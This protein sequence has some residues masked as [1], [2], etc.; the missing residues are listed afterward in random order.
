MSNQVAILGGG[1]GGL[2]A[3]HELIARG[4]SVTVYERESTFG[5]KCKSQS[6][7][8]TA[9]GGR[10]DLPTE[11]GFR[12][13]PG[14]YRHLPDVMSQIPIHGGRTCADLL[15]PTTSVLL[16]MFDKPGLELPTVFP[17]S[18][19]QMFKAAVEVFKSHLGL[20]HGEAVFFLE[21][22]WR[23]MSSCEERRLDELES[24]SWWD[25]IEADSH[26]EAYQHVLG[27]GLS[28]SL[29]A[30]RAKEASARTVGQVQVHLLSHILLGGEAT[31]RLLV[32]PTS[33]VF[34]NPW[35][36]YLSRKG[37]KFVNDAQVESLQLQ[38]NRIGGAQVRN[39]R[40]GTVQSVEADWFVAALPIE[41]FVP[42]ITP[43]LE[44]IDRQFTNLKALVGDIRWMSG[45]QFYLSDVVN[46]NHGHTLHVDT[47][48]A[49]TSISQFQFWD[50]P[51]NIWGDGQVRTLLSVVISDWGTPGLNGKTALE[52]SDRNEVLD[53]IW[54][55]LK[56][57]I[58]VDGQEILNDSAVL[59]RYLD[60]T[61][62]LASEPPV[63]EATNKDPLFINRPNS[64][65]KRPQVV[66][67]VPN[68]VLAADYV[69]SRADLAC[70]ECACESGRR[71]VN[72]LLSKT[73]STRAFCETYSLEMPCKYLREAD[74]V[75]YN[76]G[77]D[78]VHRE[79]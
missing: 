73:G 25:Y 75:A 69:Q 4:F 67:K 52:C 28:R 3:A 43:E 72:A 53:E 44:A 41:V 58:N 6:L 45:A 47:P 30:A 24:Q 55:Q 36:E 17:S 54:R 29:V 39:T 42:L 14:F 34:L 76:L 79:V 18:I 60:D 7:S 49:L 10:K 35:L 65:F 13:F 78:W 19:G 64:W 5:G 51:P 61:V 59:R 21:K 50:S 27:Q 23:V 77:I 38:G 26:S 62:K 48:W 68:L 2:T 15:T 20:E 8:G 1:L 33:E 46:L 9:S 56:K 11:H 31:D 66:T 32:G 74:K 57:S 16:T 37:V 71:A 40:T 70:M 22:L 12:F 63:G